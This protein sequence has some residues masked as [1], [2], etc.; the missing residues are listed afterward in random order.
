MVCEEQPRIEV[1]GFSGP[2]PDPKREEPLYLVK[3]VV[4]VLVGSVGVELALQREQVFGERS[5]RCGGNDQTGDHHQRCRRLAL[6]RCFEPSR[7]VDVTEKHGRNGTTVAIGDRSVWRSV[8]GLSAEVEY[9]LI[10]YINGI[11]TTRDCLRWPL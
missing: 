10:I 9:A 7:L 2:H 3:Q 5:D 4:E 6:V 11:Q 8:F 1:S